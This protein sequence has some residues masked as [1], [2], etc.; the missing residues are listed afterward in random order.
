MRTRTDIPLPRAILAAGLVLLA[1]QGLVAR[2]DVVYTRTGPVE[3][4]VVEETEEAVKVNVHYSDHPKMVW[5][6][7][8]IPRN[9]VAKVVID[10][11]AAVAYN[12][13][14]AAL[15]RKG[16]AEKHFAL[17]QWCLDN[18][19]RSEAKDQA[20]KVLAHDPAHEGARKILG[21][22]AERIVEELRRRREE[23]VPL[24]GEY[25]A[26]QDADARK[27]LF[28]ELKRRGFGSSQI[29][30]ERAARSF[31]VEKGVHLDRKIVFRADAFPGAVYSILVPEGYTPLESWPL[32]LGLHGGGA[33][34]KDGREVVGSG[35]AAMQKYQREASAR[36]YLLVCPTA[37]TAPWPNP[38]NERFI[39]ALLTEVV[40][41]CNV[42]LNRVYLV[43][44]SMGGGGT[45]H[46]GPLWTETFAAIAPLSAYG[47]SGFTTLHRS[48]TG[49]YVY[50]GDDDPRCPVESAR[51]AA[52]ALKKLKADYR[53]TELPGAGHSCPPDIVR[54]VFDFFDG[55][56]LAPS[57]KPGLFGVRPAPGAPFSSF[58][59]PFTPE[60]KTYLS[61]REATGAL[62]LVR[63]I[64]RGGGA[65]EKAASE[66]PGRDDRDRAVPG[67]RALLA[68][69]ENEDV[70][71]LCARSLGALKAEKA[72]RELGA[73]LGDEAPA[74]RASA[75]EALAAIG[76]GEARETFTKGLARVRERFDDRLVGGDR[77]DSVDWETLAGV[78]RR[79]AGA[80]GTLGD[81]KTAEALERT[82]FEGVLLKEIDVRYDAEVQPDPARS[83][84]ALALEAIAAMERIGAP[85]GAAAL[86][87]LAASMERFPDVA[88]KAGSV[89]DALE[90]AG[91]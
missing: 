52:H 44:H 22:R 78:W 7:V 1:M 39:T 73:A 11:P 53:Y 28:G 41:T 29:W 42:D 66:L 71:R 19:L 18:R 47:S 91:R 36:G 77:L 87:R 86:R 58:D 46:Y 50:H 5:E 20:G 21:S 89:A 75:A 6:V 62:A 79:V 25:A 81:A 26:L 32:V 63:E 24:I 67:L 68:R 17:A 33:A 88:A 43:G 15:E 30:L 60:E 4:F 10:R 69:S 45:W 90:A 65:A 85:A 37:I 16:D 56:R 48:G 9:Q 34:G 80:A 12:A 49:V 54:E 57:R 27:K 31:E 2:A 84:K 51:T 13:R 64:A 59:L 3:G 23:I 74:V 35:T 82:L 70:R 8:T 55:R 76:S 83:L 61:E 72:V 14:A 38:D 40:L